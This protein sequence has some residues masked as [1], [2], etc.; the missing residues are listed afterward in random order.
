MA[1]Y[2]C[3]TG[4]FDAHDQTADWRNQAHSDSNWYHQVQTQ[5]RQLALP[6][7][8]D[9]SAGSRSQEVTIATIGA[10]QQLAE[11]DKWVSLMIDPCAATHACVV[12]VRHKSKT[13]QAKQE[14][15]LRTSKNTGAQSQQNNLRTTEEQPS[16]SNM[17][18]GTCLRTSVRQWMFQTERRQAEQ[19][20]KEKQQ[21]CV[22][23][24]DFS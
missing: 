17:V 2:N 12:C 15:A 19:S 1:I 22:A 16:D 21:A 11:D 24:L 23:Q 13:A 9:S 4:N 5:V 18:Q 20:A 7:P 10:A 6:Q 14:D 3:D 8:A